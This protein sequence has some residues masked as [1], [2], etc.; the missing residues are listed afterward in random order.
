MKQCWFAIA[1]LLHIQ[2]NIPFGIIIAFTV[3]TISS[4]KHHGHSIMK[5]PLL[6]DLR[7]FQT[8]MFA[9]EDESAFYDDETQKD[10]FQNKTL[11]ELMESINS[12]RIMLPHRSDTGIK[13]AVIPI[14]FHELLQAKVDVHQI[15]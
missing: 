11:Q 1:I 9:V 15:K 12:V 10:M 6:G 4:P 13:E 8:V 5:Y 7:Q 2:S 14:W 3:T